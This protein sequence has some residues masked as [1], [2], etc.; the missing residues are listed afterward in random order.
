VTKVSVLNEAIEYIQRIKDLCV[1][2]AKDKR[3]LF[4][5]NARLHQQLAS[6]GKDVGEPK[7]WDDR[8]LMDTLQSLVNLPNPQNLNDFP[9]GMRF[10]P[11]QQPNPGFPF[12]MGGPMPPHMGVPFGLPGMPMMHPQMRMPPRGGPMPPHMGGMD[13]PPMAY[14]FFPPDFR[15]FPPRDGQGELGDQ[16]ELDPHQFSNQNFQQDQNEGQTS[17][18]E[19][20]QGEGEQ[21]R[22][23]DNNEQGAIENVTES[24]TQ[25]S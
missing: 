12:G 21:D 3:E 16:G 6:L 20:E 7:R 15:Q 5:D 14:P 9:H 4:D 17:Q 10:D 8:N 1:L 25:N 18:L 2:L 19:G 13:F 11:N 24:E 22:D 23:Q